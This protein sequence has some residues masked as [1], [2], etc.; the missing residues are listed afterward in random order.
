MVVIPS[1][2]RLLALIWSI[3]FLIVVVNTSS[4]D[5]LAEFRNCKARWYFILQIRRVYTSILANCEPENL[6]QPHKGPLPLHLRLLLWD[7][8]SECDY[9][10]QRQTTDLLRGQKQPLHQFHGKWPF[11]RLWGIQEPLSVLFSM[12]NFHGYY[13][14][15]R[16][17]SQR[18]PSSYALRPYY[19]LLG[20]F[21]MNAW[22]WSS[23][24]HTRDFLFT[25]RADYFSAGA[26]VMYGLFYVPLRLF[27]IHQRDQEKL[28]PYILIW[29]AIC[30]FTFLAHVYY[31]SFITFS[32]SYNMMANVVVG[33]AQN[34]L[35]IYYS[36]TRSRS[37]RGLWVWTPVF[38]VVYVSCAMSLEIFD[39]YPIADALDAHALWHMATIPMVPRHL[40]LS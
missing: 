5:Q 21:G 4:G 16:L 36:I 19:I 26:S 9:T 22:V 38:V 1:R 3:V 17:V 11:V 25:E 20:I 24:F 33:I 28:R 12:L 37:N 40:R 23:V 29:A 14:G 8:P 13:R 6:S 35:W 31:L 30:G 18:I 15:I 32:Y 2:G 7:C 34:I 27:N 39:F 10:C